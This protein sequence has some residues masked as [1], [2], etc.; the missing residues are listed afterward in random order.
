MKLNEKLLPKKDAVQKIKNGYVGDLTPMTS[1][2]NWVGTIIKNNHGKLDNLVVALYGIPGKDLYAHA[3]IE[4]PNGKVVTEQPGMPDSFRNSNGFV[5]RPDFSRHVIPMDKMV[6]L[7][8]ESSDRYVDSIFGYYDTKVIPMLSESD[9]RID[10]LFNGTDCYEY[11]FDQGSNYCDY[12]FIVPGPT[13]NNDPERY[14]IDCIFRLIDSENSEWSVEFSDASGIKANNKNNSKQFAILNTIVAIVTDFLSRNAGVTLKFSGELGNGKALQGQV[15]SGI[16]RS[17]SKKLKSKG[18]QSSQE[19]IDGVREFI[20]SP[21]VSENIN[22]LM[23][24][25]ILPYSRN[26]NT[27]TFEANGQVYRVY[28]AYNEFFFE[29]GEEDGSIDPTGLNNGSQF[30]II[31]TAF[32]IMKAEIERR[33]D[34]TSWSFSGEIKTEGTKVSG[35]GK[36]YHMICRR[37]FTPWMVSRGFVG[38]HDLTSSYGYDFIYTRLEEFE[39]ILTTNPEDLSHIDVNQLYGFD[40]EVF[41][42][43]QQKG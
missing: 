14:V 32:A 1:C 9:N 20:I 27:Y 4:H 39:E 11:E 37:D 2:Y 16:L 42:S 41:K 25:D 12:Q 10:E 26:G 22:E 5:D 8:Q 34:E 18:Y 7:L 40:K 6:K 3:A 30:K 19:D 35:L 21:I 29:V 38:Y 15:Y 17:L 43:Y 36:M 31:N 24:N 28:D 33:P 13:G 23:S